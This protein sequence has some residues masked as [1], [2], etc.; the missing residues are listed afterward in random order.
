[1]GHITISSSVYKRPFAVSGA[2]AGWA[3][4]T[5]PRPQTAGPSLAEPS[6]P[7]RELYAMP[8]ATVTLLD[9]AAVDV[10]G[11]LADEVRDA[12][13]QQEGIAGVSG[14]G[15][16]APEGF[17]SD[18]AVPEARWSRG[19]LGYVATGVDGG[20]DPEAAADVLIDHVFSLKAGDRRIARFGMNRV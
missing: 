18:A 9:D 15:G 10:E 5:A 11:W 1:A 20:Y 13:A 6:F 12:F 14:D 17:V 3:G 7:T 19:N 8:A 4:E 16:S 2:N